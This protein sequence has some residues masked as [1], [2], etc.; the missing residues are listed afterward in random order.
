MH[1]IP[2]FTVNNRDPFLRV[3]NEGIIIKPSIILQ[4]CCSCPK[5]NVLEKGMQLGDFV[6]STLDASRHCLAL[7]L[8]SS[9]K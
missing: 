9:G 4:Y 5:N 8:L 7:S 3:R 1:F 6:V 2:A